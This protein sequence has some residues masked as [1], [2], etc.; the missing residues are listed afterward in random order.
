MISEV[1]MVLS[2]SVLG[3][4]FF[5][6]QQ[7]GDVPPE[8]LGWLP[9][10]SLIIYV[11]AYS[12]GMGPVGYMIMGEVLPHHVKGI[13]GCLLTSAKWFMSFAMTKFFLDLIDLLGNA[14]CYWFFGASSVVGFFYIFFF[15]PETRGKT[16]DEIQR[17]FSNSYAA[18]PARRNGAE[19]DD[20]TPLLNPSELSYSANV[21]QQGGGYQSLRE[22][23]Y[24]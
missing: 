7:N 3:Y 9:L 21:G 6:K 10:S 16:L 4:Y 15:V 17:E 2:L 24:A 14:G 12:V 13:A 1:S 22:G 19:M 23:N 11:V 5:L 8:G 18:R 20:S